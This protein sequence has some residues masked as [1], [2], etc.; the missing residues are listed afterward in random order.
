MCLGF[1]AFRVYEGLG[2]RVFRVSGLFWGLGAC[3]PATFDRSAVGKSRVAED[4]PRAG[5]SCR[6]ST[7]QGLG[8]RVGFRV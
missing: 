4:A 8:F 5:C 3:I 1:R 2:F 6:T 7:K